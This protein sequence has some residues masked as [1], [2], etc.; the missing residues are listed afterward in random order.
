MQYRIC[1]V[2][3]HLVTGKH[4]QFKTCICINLCYLQRINKLECGPMPN[5]MAALPNLGGTLCSTP[6]FGW[7]PLRVAC[8]NAGKTWK[9]LK[10][11]RVPQTP[12]PISAANGLKFAILCLWG[13]VGEILL[14]NKFFF[15]LSI[16][17][18]VVK[19]QPDKSCAMVP[20]WR[21]CASFLHPVFPAVS[22]THLT[23]PTILRV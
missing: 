15:R 3:P 9:P 13:H 11:A 22:Y 23:L 6:Q 14:F 18:L 19:T 1:T 17:A 20:R 8:S 16:Y 12:E 5:V 10:F 4:Q 21:F 7:R 2:T